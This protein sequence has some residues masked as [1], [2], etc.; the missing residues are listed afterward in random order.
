MGKVLIVSKTKMRNG[1]CVGGIDIERSDFVRLH[2]DH[3]ANLPEDAPY[4]IGEV[5]EMTLESPWN[6]RNAPHIED[7]MVME[8][9]LISMVPNNLLSS[10][11]QQT[12]VSITRGSI[13]QT[14]DGH[15]KFTINGKGYVN[16]DGIPSNSVALWITDSDLIPIEEYGKK[17]YRYQNIKIPYVGFQQVEIIK[18]GTLIRL[19]LANWWAPDDG[20]CEKRC[21]LQLSGWY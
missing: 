6:P 15:L 5:W 3:G 2:T 13:N 21:Y 14:F 11:I 18:S 4:K 12:G 20:D 9:N 19:S 16:E 17:F 1:V 8:A 7:M 10:K